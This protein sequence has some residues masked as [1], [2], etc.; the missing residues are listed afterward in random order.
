MGHT[1]LPDDGC[2]GRIFGGSFEIFPNF[3]QIEI[4][5]SPPPALLLATRLSNQ[6]FRVC[7]NTRTQLFGQLASP[8]L[9]KK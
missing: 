2:D 4:N 7:G 9:T 6:L 3:F 5:F 8:A 1:V